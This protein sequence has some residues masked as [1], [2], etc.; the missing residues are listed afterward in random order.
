M[1]TFLHGI[2]AESWP[3]R[4][5]IDVNG[6]GYEVTVPMAAS[7]SFGILLWLPAAAAI[8]AAARAALCLGEHAV[9]SAAP[10]LVQRC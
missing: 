8:G 9:Q 2:L 4:V 6:V 10:Q 1:I 5:V 7:E 3:N